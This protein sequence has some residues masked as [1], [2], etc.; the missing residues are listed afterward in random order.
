MMKHKSKNCRNLRDYFNNTQ[1]E[2]FNDGIACLNKLLRDPTVLCPGN[3]SCVMLTPFNSSWRWDEKCYNIKV[4][5]VWSD[6]N[7]MSELRTPLETDTLI[8]L[9]LKEIYEDNV[10][11]ED[12]E[13][14]DFVYAYQKSISNLGQ[15]PCKILKILA[16]IL[17]DV[18]VPDRSVPTNTVLNLNKLFLIIF[19]T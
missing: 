2:E 15:D 17:A 3:L 6:E 11:Y 12:A 9:L 14:A 5:E 7:V 18:D 13:D 19:K 1:V 4:K 16:L 8:S 10:R